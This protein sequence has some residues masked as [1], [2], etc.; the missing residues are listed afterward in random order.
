MFIFI[1]MFAL[2]SETEAES[3]S[4]YV[5]D[6]SAVPDLSLF[7]SLS[8]S[9]PPPPSVSSSPL[10]SLSLSLSGSSQRER[11]AAL[12]R[13][14]HLLSPQQ[15]EDA[16]VHRDILHSLQRER[17]ER[18]TERDVGDLGRLHGIQRERERQRRR[19]RRRR[20]RRRERRERARMEREIERDGRRATERERDRDRE[21]ER[22][23]RG[24]EYVGL[25]DY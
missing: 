16:L 25:G 12:Q 17:D 6:L 15:R 7:P 2:W 21:K 13:V 8:L 14:T 9:P 5:S 20:E 18:E 4:L 1:Q 19:E 3:L 24:S 10:D 22:G 11:R 23:G